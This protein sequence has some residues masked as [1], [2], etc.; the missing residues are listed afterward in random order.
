MNSDQIL[1]HLHFELDADEWTGYPLGGIGDHMLL[2]RDRLVSI[3]IDDGSVRVLEFSR[4]GVISADTLFAFVTE[5][6]APRLIDFIA[7]ATPLRPINWD[8]MGSSE[9]DLWLERQARS[10]A[11]TAARTRTN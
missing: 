1:D 7:S 2:R 11:R 9:K 8:E 5:A 4:P 3:T 6:I 10:A